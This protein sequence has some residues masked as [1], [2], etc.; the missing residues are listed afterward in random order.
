MSIVSA[1]NDLKRPDLSSHYCDVIDTLE[2]GRLIFFLGAG[3]NLCGRDRSK[4]FVPGQDLPTGGEL[5]EYLAKKSA[6][7]DASVPAIKHL[8]DLPEVAQ[9]LYC[10]SGEQRLYDELHDVF[11]RDYQPSPVHELLAQLPGLLKK[12]GCK[13][14]H[15]LVVTTNYDVLMEKAFEGQQSPELYELVF[16]DARMHSP[17]RGK[18]L[19][20]PPDGEPKPVLDVNAFS[21]PRDQHSVVL[22]IRGTVARHRDSTDDSYVITEDHYFDYP[23]FKEFPVTIQQ[24]FRKRRFLF[25]GYSL[26]DWNLRMIFRRIWGGQNLESESWSVNSRE[27]PVQKLFWEKRNVRYEV[28][29]L[30]DYIH[31]LNLKLQSV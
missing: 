27:D 30:D 2:R 25:L 6:F 18:F 29:N 1:K 26:S 22:K 20:R 5:A 12:K 8:L 23:S 28:A 31:D 10:T 16:Y 24:E 7:P 4:P 14:P 3:V 9:Y 15:Q 13:K 11:D 17:S 21:L 19:H